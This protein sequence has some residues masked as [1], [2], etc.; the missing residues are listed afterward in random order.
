MSIVICLHILERIP[1]SARIPARLTSGKR[2]LAEARR[3]GMRA[4][5]GLKFQCLFR[6]SGA[7]PQIFVL[8]SQ[9]L[10]GAEFRDA[11]ERLH[12]CLFENRVLEFADARFVASLMRDPVMIGLVWDLQW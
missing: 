5:P 12:P 10:R 8:E 11:R 3:A 4:L 1:G 2:R 9:S 7:T 6:V